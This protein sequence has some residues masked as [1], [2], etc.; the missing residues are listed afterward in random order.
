MK[1][2]RCLLFIALVFL[3]GACASKKGISDCKIK[4]VLEVKITNDD[5]YSLEVEFYERGTEESRK[6][7]MKNEI[8]RRYPSTQNKK[9]YIREWVGKLY[10]R[11]IYRIDIE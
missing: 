1:K 4:R 8:Y 11:F 9:I 7:L 3:L 5:S 10:N 6:D 2:N